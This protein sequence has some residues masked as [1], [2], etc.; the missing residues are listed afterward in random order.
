MDTGINDGIRLAGNFLTSLLRP[1]CRRRWLLLTAGLLLA[2]VWH[3]E[4]ASRFD[5]AALDPAPGPQVLDRQGRT[6]R[7]VWKP[8]DRN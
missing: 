3:L 6:L 7:L 8:R 4:A 2:L 1:L 5:R